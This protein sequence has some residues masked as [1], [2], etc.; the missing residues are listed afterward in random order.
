MRLPFSG[1]YPTTQGFNDSCCRA[2]YAK[3]GMQGHNGIDYGLPT[4]TKVV[5]AH[6]G[7]VYVGTEPG[8]Y[9]NYIFITG[10]GYESVY[11]H[12]QKP[13]VSTGQRVTEGQEIAL[14]NNTGNSS[15][16][17]LHFGVRPIGYNRNN[18]FLGY[19]DP[20]PLFNVQGGSMATKVTKE[21]LRM[22][23]SEMEGWPFQEVHAGKFDGQFWASW[24][25]QDL[26]AAMWEKWN[27]NGNYRN[28]REAALKYWRE[29]K[30]TV[31]EK[32]KTLDATIKQRDELATQVTDLT[33][34]V[35][36]LTKQYQDAVSKPTQSITEDQAVVV[37]QEKIN[38]IINFL[39]KVFSWK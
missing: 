9:G 25:G 29:E 12:L 11:G 2:S 38:P 22:I 16:P 32:L 5:A 19:I 33:K 8:G 35:S 23:H 34:K 1:S 15:G 24:G 6:N 39:R 36:D 10:D 27:K 17:H 13:L 37:V 21:T 30:K 4:G 14:S 28:E 20:L 7:T 3:F 26:E 31:D 18:G